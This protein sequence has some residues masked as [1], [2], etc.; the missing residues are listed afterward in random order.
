MDQIVRLGELITAIKS[1]HPDGDPLRQLT[2]AVVLGEQ[3]GEVADHLIGH[4]VDQA[5]HAGASWTDIGRSMGV[6]KQAAQKRFVPKETSLAEDLRSYGR[7]TERTRAVIVAAQALAR[8][9]GA[10]HIEPQHLVL[11]L[12]SEPQCL[13]V[14]A[15]DALGASPDTVRQ[16]MEALTSSGEAHGDASAAPTPP[17]DSEEAAGAA[18]GPPFS[19]LSRKALELTL[20]EALHLGHN[21]VGTEHVLL[22]VLS[23]GEAPGAHPVVTVLEGLGVTKEAAE[24]EIKELLAAILRDRT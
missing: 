21:Y 18:G 5:R 2:D 8:D 9:G 12:L 10:G 13:A 3:L 7:F 19:A 11:G 20:R 1:R 4:F 14:R 6:T 23:L 16:A 22:G 17:A 24:R 15:M